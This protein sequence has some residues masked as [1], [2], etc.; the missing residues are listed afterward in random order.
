MSLS[1]SSVFAYE[2]SVHSSNILLSLDDQRKKDVLCDVTVLVEGQH[3]R[4]HRSVLAACSSYLHSRVI[5]QAEAQLQITL[6]EEVSD[7]PPFVSGAHTDCS[8]A[9]LHSIAYGL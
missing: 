5:G 4:A 7:R 2:S 1:A 8:L 9:E 6:P 3:F